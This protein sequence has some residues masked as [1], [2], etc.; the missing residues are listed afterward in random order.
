MSDVERLA[1][2]ELFHYTE[3]ERLREAMNQSLAKWADAGR[4]LNTAEAEAWNKRVEL[5]ESTEAPS[6]PRDLIRFVLEH[7]FEGVSKVGLSAMLSRCSDDDLIEE[8]LKHGG[9]DVVP[10]VRLAAYRVRAWHSTAQKTF[11]RAFGHAAETWLRFT[12]PLKCPELRYSHDPMWKS[13][14]ITASSIKQLIVDAKAEG[15]VKQLRFKYKDCP[16]LEIRVYGARGLVEV[17]HPNAAEV[18]KLVGTRCVQFKSEGGYSER[19]CVTTEKGLFYTGYERPSRWANAHYHMGRG[20]RIM[21]TR[22]TS[23]PNLK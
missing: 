17:H 7:W 3:S 5:Y 8:L 20:N 21:A 4:Q 22:V 10:N 18:R 14:Y 11:G 9:A 12:R 23:N 16:T 6:I 1:A 15:K 13:K 19:R 2:L